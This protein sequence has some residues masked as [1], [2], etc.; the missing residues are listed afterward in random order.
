[1]KDNKIYI[2]IIAVLFVYCLAIGNSYIDLSNNK[3][4]ISSRQPCIRSNEFDWRIISGIESDNLPLNLNAELCS[5]DKSFL[6]LK[7]IIHPDSMYLIF[8]YPMDYCGECVNEICTL[9]EV[10]KDSIPCINI[11]ILACSGFFRDM[12]V[13][14]LP[15]KDKFPLYLMLLKNIGLPLDNSNIPYMIFVNDGKTTK[16]TLIVDYGSEEFLKKYIQ[17]L[18]KRYCISSD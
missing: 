8:K 4:Q 10:L 17:M 3:T 1:M 5:Y 11:K 9:L 16:H 12:R 6:T 13:K 2:V 15:Y 14:L 18:S 7:N